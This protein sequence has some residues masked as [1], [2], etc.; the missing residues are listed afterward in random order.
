M[1]KVAITGF[2][3]GFKAVQARFR[4]LFRFDGGRAVRC[5]L[6]QLTT[7]VIGE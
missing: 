6:A 1:A 2:I 7:K 4:P 5:P 3:T